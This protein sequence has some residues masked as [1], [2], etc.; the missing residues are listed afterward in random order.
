MTLTQCSGGRS[1]TPRLRTSDDQLER[2]LLNLDSLRAVPGLSNVT[3][4]PTEESAVFQDPDPRG[5]C[6]AVISPL[7]LSRSA[8]AVFVGP[9]ITVI[10][11]V[12]QTSEGKARTYFDEMLEDAKPGCQA[13]ASKTNQGK[14]QRVDTELVELGPLGDQ[15]LGLRAE[16]DVGSQ[17]IHFGRASIR[18]GNRVAEGIV[19]A[20]QPVSETMLLEIAKQI[21][22]AMGNLDATSK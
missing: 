5:P 2:G 8:V 16:I 22:L 19:S 3:A 12:I 10:E 4:Q 15:R 18:I 7:S 21:E 20:N 6:G 11:L 17:T 1:S 9:G 13:Y 14:T